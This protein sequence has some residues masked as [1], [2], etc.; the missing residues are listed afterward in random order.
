MAIEIASAVAANTPVVVNK[1][2][3]QN[4]GDQQRE[5][6]RPNPALDAGVRPD[7]VILTAAAE[8]LRKTE[9]RNNQSPPVNSQRIAALQERIS[10]GTY[11]IDAARVADKLLKFEGS[12]GAVRQ[13]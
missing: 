10:N 1:T 9:S 4:P 8:R 3:S 12:L 13:N 7:R 6:Q 5:L 11:Q 2:A